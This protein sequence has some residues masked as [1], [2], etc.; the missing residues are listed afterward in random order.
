M[1]VLSH[2]TGHC[3]GW[4]MIHPDCSVI[5]VP[6]EEQIVDGSSGDVSSAH[7]IH[8]QALAAV[9]GQLLAV[10]AVIPSFV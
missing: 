8:S 10:T 9:F 7:S 5:S 3:G 2:L 1:F 6:E 4:V